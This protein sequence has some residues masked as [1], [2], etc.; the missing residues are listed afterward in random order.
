MDNSNCNGDIGD[1][2]DYDRDNHDIDVYICIN[3]FWL[4]TISCVFMPSFS[5]C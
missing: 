1:N 4:V 5:V 2:S 3:F